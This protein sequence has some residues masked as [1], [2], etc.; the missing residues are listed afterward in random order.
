MNMQGERIDFP[1]NH[2]L[3]ITGDEGIGLLCARHF[4]EHYGVKTGAYRP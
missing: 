4:A 1:D 3:L 2:V